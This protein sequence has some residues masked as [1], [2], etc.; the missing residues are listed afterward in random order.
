MVRFASTAVLAASLLCGCD[1]VGDD[2]VGSEGGTVISRDGRLS[3]EI[4]EGALT[5]PTEITIEEV[6]DLPEGAVGPSYR[7]LPVGTVFEAPVYLHYE[8][9]AMG[10]E[11]AADDL[12]LVVERQDDWT[13]L[14]DRTVH[15]DETIVSASALYLSTF[16]IIDRTAQ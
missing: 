14:A 6:D 15:E 8:Y 9:G 12:E 13:S 10:M 3:L 11:V 4:P 2:V 7:V 1:P 16:G 5:D